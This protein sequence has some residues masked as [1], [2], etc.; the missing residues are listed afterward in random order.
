MS[1]PYPRIGGM[2]SVAALRSRLQSL[3]AEMPCDDVSLSAPTSPL[4]QPLTLQGA[5]GRRFELSNRF[6]IQPMEGWD[7]TPD[8]FPSELTVRRWRNFGR[9]QAAWIWGGEAAAVRADGKANPNQLLIDETTA[10]AIGKLRKELLQEADSKCPPL[11]GLQLTHSGRWARSAAARAG[12]TIRYSF[13]STA[14]PRI[15]FRHPLLD[16]RVGV[17]DDRV[18]LSDAD[19]DDLIS[20]FARAAYLAQE[21]GFDFVDIKHCHGYLLHEL[22]AARTRS[23]RFGGADLAQRTRFLFAVLDAVRAAAPR[24]SVG[25][26]LS[27][28]DTVPH[29]PQGL[30]A[31]GRLG[32]GIPEQAPLPYIYGFGI[33]QLVPA[34]ADLEEPAALV[35][36]LRDAGVTWLNVT[37]GSPYY[38]PHIQRPALFPPSDGYAPPEDPLLGVHRLLVAAR[39]IKAAVPEM[40]VVSSGWTYLQEYI[41]HVAQACVRQGWFDAV[42]L[43]RMVLSYPEL[44]ADVLGGRP[45]LR[46]RL[47]RTFSDCTTAPRKG[48]VSGCYPLDPFYRALP[49]RA[50]VEAAK[51]GK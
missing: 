47:C 37:A 6:V 26:R 24:V 36:M 12:D 42:G 29:R 22:L 48:F 19:L 17:T 46:K 13:S 34:Q 51:R 50:A 7:G 5:A 40:V 18:L 23:G 9:S 30:T 44:P 2:G 14:A 43:G 8:G 39:D 31:E 27:L 11:V 25:V 38:V 21:E 41:P 15:A 32:P 49:E 1:D 20:C 10:A 3:G 45:L 33:D 28:F 4:A 16:G 35:R